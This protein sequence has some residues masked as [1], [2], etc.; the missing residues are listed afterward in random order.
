M[1][2]SRQRLSAHSLLEC[3]VEDLKL[4][5]RSQR[6]RGL[7]TSATAMSRG[8]NAES[9]SPSPSQRPQ[10][11]AARPRPRRQ[12][13][14]TSA[15]RS[16]PRRAPLPVCNPR[17]NIQ[18]S[19]PVTNVSRPS[20]RERGLAVIEAPIRARSTGREAP[21]ELWGQLLHCAATFPGPRG[22]LGARR[23]RAPQERRR[24]PS[25]RLR[26]TSWCS[27]CR[28]IASRHLV[29]VTGE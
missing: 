7:G 1:V 15:R 12:P 2:T 17:C 22:G 20:P 9:G 29:E 4:P 25:L 23:P 28:S 24:P 16:A 14:G 10:V 27:P 21:L 19:P 11:G 18:L 8:R 13:D 5:A 6:A 26:R 3:C